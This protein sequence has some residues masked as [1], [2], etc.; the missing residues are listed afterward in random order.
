[1]ALLERMP[2]F[3]SVGVDPSNAASGTK[4]DRLL[5]AWSLFHRCQDHFGSW[6]FNTTTTKKHSFM[7]F[8]NVRLLGS[9]AALAF[10]GIGAANAQSFPATFRQTGSTNSVPANV[11][12]GF[13]K[14]TPDFK[15][16]SI[17]KAADGTMTHTTAT[18]PLP[19]IPGHPVAVRALS[20][21]IFPQGIL[22]LPIDPQSQ[23]AKAGD[24]AL[25]GGVALSY[26]QDGIFLAFTDFRED[27]SG[28]LFGRFFVNGQDVGGG[29]I[30]L[31]N[32]TGAK[33]GQTSDHTQFT[34]S[35]KLQISAAFAQLVNR[36]FHATVLSPGQQ[37]ATEDLV[38]DVAN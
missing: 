27:N 2:A 29:E 22:F 28:N 16:N 33:I 36:T 1:M 20:P 3:A 23:P 30:E 34:I 19:A 14:F 24:F 38:A 35:A 6:N 13:A 37:I 9:L 26:P 25:L 11:A 4:K 5:K 8:Y 15:I 31:A 17:E 7:R 32:A 12:G 21:A 10:L 18:F